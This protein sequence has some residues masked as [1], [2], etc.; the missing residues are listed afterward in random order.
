MTC[1]AMNCS[2]PAGDFR[3]WPLA[4]ASKQAPQTT[5]PA[6]T[7]LHISRSFRYTAL[8]ELTAVEATSAH[9]PTCMMAFCCACQHTT[10]C[11]TLLLPLPLP[12][13]LLL[14]LLLLP[15]GTPWTWRLR[16]CRAGAEQRCSGSS[17]SHS[18]CK[19]KGASRSKFDGS[20]MRSRCKA[21]WR[22]RCCR[23]GA[24]QLFEYSCASAATSRGHGVAGLQLSFSESNARRG[25]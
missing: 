8:A 15:P 17:Y 13:L 21:V 1:I 3:H 10:W 18:C 25:R 20:S 4:L 12:L 19:Q 24:E 23:A 7:A 14:L 2:T 22:L 16:C 9:Q 11:L 6:H 5:A